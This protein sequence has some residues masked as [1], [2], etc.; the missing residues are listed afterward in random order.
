MVYIMKHLTDGRAENLLFL[1]SSDLHDLSWELLD[2]PA[3]SN[4]CDC[5]ESSCTSRRMRSITPGICTTSAAFNWT[6]W[7]VL[8]SIFPTVKHGVVQ[9]AA[10]GPLTITDVNS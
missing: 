5:C 3:Y 9:K 10:L 1:F 2:N 6:N 8:S 7:I 4:L